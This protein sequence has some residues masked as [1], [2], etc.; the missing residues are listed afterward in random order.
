V[1]GTARLRRCRSERLT[2]VVQRARAERRTVA[3]STRRLRAGCRPSAP[4]AAP[5]PAGPTRVLFSTDFTP[6]LFGPLP[7]TPYPSDVDDGVAVA[8]ALNAKALRV[9]GLAIQFG[10]NE[11]GPSTERARLMVHEIMGRRDIPIAK[12]AEAKLNP[13]PPSGSTDPCVND[14]VRLLSRL[15]REGPA[16]IVAAGPLTDV[17]CLARTDAEAA[18]N[19]VEILAQIGARPGEAYDLNG[20][21]ALFSLNV[22]VDPEATRTVLASPALAHATIIAS[23]YHF[24]GGLLLDDARV[25]RLGGSSPEGIWLREQAFAFRAFWRVA[26][27]DNGLRPWDQTLVYRLMHPE[28]TRTVDVG[29]RMVDCS[30][31]TGRNIGSACAG[32]G[33]TQFPTRDGEPQQLWL[34]EGPG[35]RARPH[36]RILSDYATPADGTRFL[37]AVTALR[38]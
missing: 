1:R 25:D 11:A 22:G 32:H 8:L 14:G 26:F 4:P 29:W 18:A 34:G 35:Q 16:T 20:R 6:G 24:A 31:P 21:P 3:R 5:A 28:A 17:A 19:V 23:P 38:G 27:G 7:Q 37:D 9:D 36:L 12:G 13:A 33:P 10:N 30:D 15:L 2:I